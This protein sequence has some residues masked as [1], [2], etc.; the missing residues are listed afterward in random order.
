[1]PWF[2]SRRLCDRIVDRLEARSFPSSCQEQFFIGQK[3]AWIISLITY[4]ARHPITP[5]LKIN[6]IA[7]TRSKKLLWKLKKAIEISTY[8]DRFIEMFFFKLEPRYKKHVSLYSKLKRISIEW[9]SCLF[10]GNL[11]KLS[12]PSE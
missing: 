2:S 8:I 11:N 7:A 9:V 12:K 4:K 5:Y 6:L 1:M 10:T 3:L